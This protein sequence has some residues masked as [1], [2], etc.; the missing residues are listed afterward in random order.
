VVGADLVQSW[1]GRVV[2]VPTVAGFSTSNLVQ[3]LSAGSESI[4][5]RK[6]K[7]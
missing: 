3:K 1:G 2:I 4:R 6:A 5:A 7:S